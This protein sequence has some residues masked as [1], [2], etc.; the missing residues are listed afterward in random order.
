[1][2]G[3]ELNFKDLVKPYVQDC[4]P[5]APAPQPP[6]DFGKGYTRPYTDGTLNKD[7]PSP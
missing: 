1:M 4:V 2:L 5:P 6:E 3:L 7:G